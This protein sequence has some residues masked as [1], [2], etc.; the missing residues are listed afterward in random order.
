MTN[1]LTSSWRVGLGERLLA[2]PCAAAQDRGRALLELGALARLALLA[3]GEVEAL[4]R[5]VEADRA[6]H[7][8]E[9]P[10][11]R[12]HD[13]AR[14]AGLHALAGTHDRLGVEQRGHRERDQ[15]HAEHAAGG[16]GERVAVARVHWSEL[17]VD[18]GGHALLADGGVGRHDHQAD[19]DALGD[20]RPGDRATP[21]PAA[22]SPR[23][24][25]CS[26]IVATTRNTIGSV[27]SGDGPPAKIW[28]IMSK[29]VDRSGERKKIQREADD[30]ERD[31][32]TPARP[33]TRSRGAPRAQRS[34]LS[35]AAVDAAP[36]HERPGGAVPEAAEQHRQHQVAV[37]RAAARR[38]CR[39]AGCRGSRA[40]SA[41][42]SCAS[43]ARS[44]AGSAPGRGG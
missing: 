39:R 42:A 16:H 11:D 20:H 41:T 43:A 9:R 32:A 27:T 25:A 24:T 18:E 15:D 21:R 26:A 37:G 34:T 17:E 2:A 7:V 6:G 30:V 3:E 29:A 33:A 35:A 5:Q 4:A 13:V 38:G 1:T 40:A 36:D 14:G 10:A 19:R 31:Q 44:P 23:R 22:R 12:Q 28:P 8:V